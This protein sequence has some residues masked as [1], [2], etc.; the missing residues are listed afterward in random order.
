MNADLVFNLIKECTK[1][2]NEIKKKQN[3]DLNT[4]LVN[5]LNNL[6]S[7]KESLSKKD[8]ENIE[9]NLLSISVSFIESAKQVLN[10]KYHKHYL[11]LLVL[12]KKF[13]EYSL[14]SKEK[15][16][17]V[18]EL[19]KDFYNHPKTS[20]ECQN[21][22]IEILQTLIFSSFFE[23]KYDTLSIIF[24]LILKSFNN[25]NHSKN[26]D[27]KNPIRLILSTLT[28]KV[29]NSNNY[30]LIIQTTILIFSWYNLSLKKKIESISRKN[31]LELNKAISEV[32]NSIDSSEMSD[33]IDDN[34][35]EEINS[36][37][38]Q[39]KNNTYIQCLSLELLSQG[40]ILINNNKE[41]KE[42][43][44]TDK[45]DI[46]YLNKFIKNKVLKTLMISLENIKKNNSVSEEG[47]NYLH[48]LKLCRFVKIII[49]YYDVNYDIIQSIIDIMNENQNKTIW[50]TNISFELLSEIITNYE[51]LRKIYIWKKE[52]VSTIFTCI[53]NFIKYIGNLK[54]E[55][56]NKKVE[57]N[58][59]S[60]FM[61]K[62]ELNVNKIY[63]EGDQ[64]EISKEHSKKF[65]KSF[66]NDCLQNIIDS[67]IKYNKMENPNVKIENQVLE[68]EIFEIIC[69]NVK[70]ILFKLL[71]IE[72]LQI[73]INTNLQGDCEIKIYINFVQ[74][75]MGL[76]NNLKMYEKRDEYLKYLC[77]MALDFSDEKDEDKNI[78]IAINILGISKA[79]HLLNKDAFVL[80]LKTLQVF[81]RKY[82]YIKLN[83][84]NKKDLDKII[85]DIN[86]LYK[87][88]NKLDLE[89]IPIHYIE[90]VPLFVLVVMGLSIPAAFI[91]SLI[92]KQI[93]K[94][95]R[96]KN[97]K[98][99][100]EIEPKTGEE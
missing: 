32:E 51:V 62:K 26:K 54:E 17:N 56:E 31:S 65:Y 95:L 77:N 61:K 79:T 2:F 48:Y 93:G 73:N 88:F 87:K 92:D 84:Y 57:N 100:G 64:I 42:K 11:N 52:L 35:K 99:T 3:E 46:N 76:F 25:T 44:K 15:A 98:K 55:K 70:D 4:S 74:S 14:F 90:N 82:N 80:I 78:F 20:D 40:F 94:L 27:F 85:K 5:C 18:I 22:I 59:I 50:K 13:I 37:I 72:F 89:E 58:I 53:N 63:L 30:E 91:L 8:E 60:N 29:Y 34:L 43:E 45:F 23:I 83:E 86:R 38:S 19:L 68:K 75:M 97:K 39:K 12:L 24:I 21:K 67:I 7:L 28:E 41:E 9:Q 69:N 66:L 33:D 16:G 10:L 1:I 6:N 71:Y 81:N 47:L 96:P 36:V 49:F